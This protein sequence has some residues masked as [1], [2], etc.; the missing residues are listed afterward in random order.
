[1]MASQAKTAVAPPKH[2][3]PSSSSCCASKGRPPVRRWFHWHEPGTTKEEKWLLFKLDLFI[4]TYTCLTFFVKYLDQTNVT[5]AYISGMKEDLDMRGNELNWLSTYFNIGIIIGSPFTATALTVIHPRFWL[6]ACTVTWSVMVL[7]MYKA[8]N[9]KTLYILRFFCGLAES[10]VLPGAWYIIGSWYRKS[11]IARRTALFYFSSIGGLML[12]GY[13]QAGLYHNMNNRLGLAAWRWLFILDF[14]I[15]IPIAVLG[16]C[17]CPDEPKSKR[18]WWMTE[19]ERQRCIERLAEEGRDAEPVR[20]SWAKF[21]Q[22]FKCW[23]LY[24]FCIAWGTYELNCA[25]NLQRWMGLWLK[26]LKENGHPKYSIEEINALPTVIGCLQLIWMLLGS[27]TADWLQKTSVVIAAL[28]GV[29]MIGYIIFCVW[30]ASD[31][32]IM[33]AFYV[34]SAYGAIGPL[35]GS[36]LNSCSGGDKILR[37]LSSSLMSSVGL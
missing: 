16:F 13:I 17:V 15:S 5:N 7:C 33:A 2:P 6:P 20:W 1:M 36:W 23:Q 25:V 29:Q 22:L 9:V 32:A 35:M 14:V 26:S 3:M 31:S 37:A 21:G 30:P 8:T 10:G 19:S 27:F 34:S 12:S 11:E 24:G 18:I 28:A 4:L